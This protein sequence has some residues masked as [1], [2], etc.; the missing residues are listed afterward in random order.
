MVSLV[1]G[2]AVGPVSLYDAGELD[3]L[4]AALMARFAARTGTVAA[5]PD[6]D[7]EV[8]G[9]E[10]QRRRISRLTRCAQDEEAEFE[11][12][13]FCTDTPGVFASAATAGFAAQPPPLPVP[14]PPLPLPDFSESEDDEPQAQPAPPPQPTGA[15]ARLAAPAQAAKPSASSP[16]FRLGRAKG[17]PRAP[18]QP[19]PSRLRAAAPPAPSLA[20][21]SWAVQGSG[22]TIGAGPEFALLGSIGVPPTQP[23]GNG[24]GGGAA[25]ASPEVAA[26]LE[27]S[28][29]YTVEL[30]KALREVKARRAANACL[31]A[32]L[33][34]PAGGGVGGGGAAASKPLTSA[35][36][37]STRGARAGGF[38]RLFRVPQDASPGADGTVAVPGANEDA[39][40]EAWALACS[41]VPVEGSGP[42]AKLWSATERTQ[43]RSGVA[44]QLQRA[45]M[46]AALDAAAAGG[47]G[48]GGSGGGGSGGGG[49]GGGSG[50]RQ[51][52]LEELRAVAAAAPKVPLFAPRAK[53]EGG[54]P[55]GV[56]RNYGM[57]TLSPLVEH[58]T[59]DAEDDGGEG[60]CGGGDGGGGGG[61]GAGGGGE[62]AAALSPPQPQQQLALAPAPGAPVTS[63]PDVS[64][65]DWA[66]LAALRLPGRCGAEAAVRWSFFE[67]PGLNLSPEWSP[68]ED[69]ALRALCVKHA[70]HN[71]EAVAA[72]LGA[73][74]VAARRPLPF[75][76]PAMCLRRYVTALCDRAVTRNWSPSEDARLIELV[77]AA[78]GGAGG[79]G[80]GGSGGNASSAP[81]TWHKWGPIGL[82][83]NRDPKACQQRYCRAL[84]P[85]MKKGKWGREEDDKLRA[86]VAALGA[87]WTKV[88]AAVGGR[89]DM[90]C[91]ERW[92]NCLDPKLKF[93]KWT[94]DED[95][96]LRSA[97]A[98]LA[99][100]GEAKVRWAA[101]AALVAPRT[102]NQCML[103]HR[104]LVIA[105][106]KAA[107]RAA[108]GEEEEE[109]EEKPSKKKAKA[110]GGK[111]KAG[112][113]K[114]G[115][116]QKQR[117]KA[118]AAAAKKPRRAATKKAAAAD[119]DSSESGEAEDTSSEGEAE[120]EEEAPPPVAPAPDEPPAA[121]AA[122]A[123][124]GPAPAGAPATTAAAVA[125]P[126]PHPPPPPLPPLPSARLQVLC[127][128]ARGVLHLL[129]G[130]VC[131]V[132]LYNPLEGPSPRTADAVASAAAEAD[133]VAGT[134]AEAA[135]AK[136]AGNGASQ[137]P[138][139]LPQPLPPPPPLASHHASLTLM[140]FV[141]AGGR[142]TAN[143]W[144]SAV[145]VTF[146]PPPPLPHP[147]A[148][149]PTPRRAHPWFAHVAAAASVASS[150]ASA[151]PG[152]PRAAPPVYAASDAAPRG[153][154]LGLWLRGAGVATKGAG[155]AAAPR[156]TRVTKLWAADRRVR[157]AEGLGPAPPQAETA[158]AGAAPLKAPPK[159]KKAAVAAADGDGAGADEAGGDAN[160]PANA[161]E[162]ADAG[163]PAAAAAFGAK[164]SRPKKEGDK[165][166]GSAKK[167]AKKAARA[168]AEAEEAKAE[169]PLAGR[170]PRRA[171]AARA[172]ELLAEMTEESGGDDDDDDDDDGGAAE[173]EEGGGAGTGDKVWRLG[174]DSDCDIDGG[175]SDGGE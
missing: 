34:V 5:A 41:R 172:T 112:G 44:W 70:G 118:G 53:G 108:A 45:H 25:G 122:D 137:Q 71:W 146:P 127:G 36:Q 132:R 21:P 13:A 82:A 152:A 101:V 168:E 113:L 2:G 6:A 69:A 102:D 165:P 28:R 14:K 20:L 17:A 166:A 63:Q 151:P 90:Q 107:A 83:L 61:G 84:K 92:V 93:G 33:A 162:G 26:Q 130:K 3:A 46:E 24:G 81:I 139:P 95:A 32:S 123:A 76:S 51:M 60:G 153:L 157:A 55:S 106:G 43:L 94:P 12:D 49:G 96:K 131:D 140:A 98:Q 126:P 171:A 111:A 147:H 56:A 9:V 47:S 105:D 144:V 4:E 121:D 1:E 124:P 86:A 38:S 66:H 75:R 160:A 22:L 150:N 7:A 8:R 35:G 85:D 10:G 65:V 89:T 174:G 135:R 97:Y 48:G 99:R 149:E 141:V 16:A 145:R 52:T 42:R 128:C 72:E 133:A 169:G 37:L 100:G 57:A 73:D 129:T 87:A 64:S 29:E 50:S 62:G 39:K 170:R 175:A 54:K 91:R 80:G 163:E 119:S 27:A 74:G 156:G 164:R 138:Q 109:E 117:A 40:S 114:R 136:A 77:A 125:S 148:A 59:A 167:A 159:K 143:G 68:G 173:A 142:A 23:G 78:T 155:E 134:L 154:A 120:E 15:P 158:A 110:K 115:A 31:R 67:A 104:H 103:R 88:S 19:G 116:P 79:S 30:V 11:D 18:S 58:G 161:G